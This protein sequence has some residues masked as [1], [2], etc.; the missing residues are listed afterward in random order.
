[1]EQVLLIV[2]AVAILVYILWRVD[3]HRE[4]KFKLLS[5]E[6]A[7]KQLSDEAVIKARAEFESRLETE[8]DLPDGIRWRAAFIY[9]NLMRQWF[10]S[11]LASSRYTGASD[12]L[13]ADWVDYM[14]LMDRRARL[15]FLSTETDNEQNRKAYDEEGIEVSRK[16]TLI[17]DAMAAAIGQEAAAQL[18]I[19][20][21]RPH[22]A[23]DRSGKKPMAPVGLHYFPTS[24]RP[25]VEELVPDK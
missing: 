14:H 10:A 8:V 24:I 19:A 13:K 20:R 9:W 22:D 2:C 16:I 11:L 4:H 17:E 6:Y 18:E 25:Y 23:F 7:K 5:D 12:K 21:S 15:N 3:Q 1:M